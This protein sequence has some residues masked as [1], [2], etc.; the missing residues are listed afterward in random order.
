MRRII[1]LLAIAVAAV[2]LYAASASAQ[3]QSDTYVVYGDS[4]TSGYGASYVGG[5]VGPFATYAA[6]KLGHPVTVNNQ[7][8][9]G[10]DSSFLNTIASWYFVPATDQA[11]RFITLGIGTKDTLVTASVCAYGDSTSCIKQYADTYQANLDSLVAN[12]V[13]SCQ[14]HPKTIYLS[15]IYDT[16]SP[17]YN[18]AVM[19]QTVK[20]YNARINAVA[21]KYGLTVVDMY[22]AINGPNDIDPIAAGLLGDGLHPNDRGYG[23]MAAEQETYS[24]APDC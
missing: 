2:A 4:I 6:G 10:A 14:G 7:S 1:L 21:A 9:W 8:V 16:H 13:S 17:Y 12:L 15:N 18:R 20:E 24:L 19:S 3:T 11:A 23:V 22:A 5:Y